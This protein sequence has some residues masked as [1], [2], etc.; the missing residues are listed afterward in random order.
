[1]PERTNT[2]SI[3]PRG[4]L[5]ARFN[6]PRTTVRWRLTLLYGALF[7]ASGATLLAITYALVADATLVPVKPQSPLGPVRPHSQHF[8]F[9]RAPARIVAA[10]R[11]AGGQILIKRVVEKQR[12]SD[13]HQL[14][15]E[16][17]IALGIMALLSAMLGWVVAGRV[18]APLRMITATTQ[19]ISESN[20]H[21][22]L[23]MGGP[24]DELRQLADAI[25]R[26][27]A[28][29]EAAFDAQRLFVAN[30]SHEL[31]TPLALM[32]T[33][34]D[35]AVAKPGGVP[36]QL[37]TVD[38]K[39]RID[40]DQ[41]DRLL[42]S[43]L[44]LASAQHGELGEERSVALRSDDRHGARCAHGSDRG[45]GDRGPPHPFS[46]RGRRGARRCSHG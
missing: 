29:L 15:I 18:L 3:P 6:R 8:Y 42:E 36:P 22:R 7:L 24:P 38:A 1:M 41:A 30:A 23:Q 14:V 34:L 31:R 32:R 35:V 26:L 12:I 33:T 17:G 25:D 46:G 13:L 21:E 45:K 4:W 19:E 10:L 40:L 2:S 5:R 43:F 11:S 27:L 9:V 37:K 16:S 39:L 44:V 28:R 20:L